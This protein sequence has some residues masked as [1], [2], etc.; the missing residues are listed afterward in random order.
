MKLGHLVPFKEALGFQKS[1]VYFWGNIRLSLSLAEAMGYQ[2]HTLSL[3]VDNPLEM[4][5]ALLPSP[6]DMKRK[7][8]A[9]SLA[10]LI[11]E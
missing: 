10:H 4:R 9:G 7:Q 8:P 11:C 1:E 3:I 6:L 2:R 5:G